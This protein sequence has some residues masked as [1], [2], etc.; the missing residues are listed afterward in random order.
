M[1]PMGK[2]FAK[3]FPFFLFFIKNYKYLNW[4]KTKIIPDNF[5][6]KIAKGPENKIE[7]Y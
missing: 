3:F 1:S 5:F 6:L 4:I 7:F 2:I